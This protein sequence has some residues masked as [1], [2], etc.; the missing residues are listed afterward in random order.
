MRQQA[1][2]SESAGSPRPNQ[3]ILLR[4]V[5]IPVM[6]RVCRHNPVQAR[7]RATTMGCWTMR[8]GKRGLAYHASYRSS[9]ALDTCTISVAVVR[10]AQSGTERDRAGQS[11]TGRYNKRCKVAHSVCVCRVC[12]GGGGAGGH[13]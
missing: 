4:C 8:R 2:R 12:V 13:R 9:R 10:V 6:L 3:S 7:F 11:G 5:L 1:L